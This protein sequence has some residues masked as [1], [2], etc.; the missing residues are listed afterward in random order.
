M[1]NV[2]ACVVLANDDSDPRQ[3]RYADHVNAALEVAQTAQSDPSPH[4]LYAWLT[5]G[6]TPPGG[7]LITYGTHAGLDFYTLDDAAFHSKPLYGA[8]Q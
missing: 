5:A 3:S 6:S 8:R 4:G 7:G 1:K 2:N